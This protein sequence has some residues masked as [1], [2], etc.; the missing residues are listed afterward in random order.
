MFAIPSAALIHAPSTFWSLAVVCALFVG[1]SKTG[2][3]GIGI[4]T[5]GIMANL[6]DAGKSTGLLL[7]MLIVGD[8]FTLLYYRRH[9]VWRHAARTL[10]W[11]MIGIL[12][13]WAAQAYH[14]FA[15]QHLRQVIG[16]IVLAVLILGALVPQNR[17]ELSVPNRWW[18]AALIGILGGF[19]T[20]TAN[21][22]GPI[23]IVYLLAMQIPKDAFLGTSGWIFLILN[24][25]KLPFSHDLGYITAESLSF[26]L[27]MIPAIGLGAL[28][29]IL[30]AK[31]IPQR[32]FDLAV[33]ALAV[34]AAIRLITG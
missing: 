25:F 9:A 29:G 3:P 14:D 17:D 13:G 4:L 33:K 8:V 11:G 15:P 2:I 22:A 20:M 5:V 18:F 26:D 31:R 28:A 30:I 10:P 16:A 19:T 21:A 23:W 12:G 1:L 32:G 6:F 27:L 7:P 34:A 24:T